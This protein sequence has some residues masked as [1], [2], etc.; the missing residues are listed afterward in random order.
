MLK[1]PVSTEDHVQGPG[2]AGVTLV[3]YGDY[4]CPYCGR[5]YPVVKRLQRHFG[6]GLRF[7][8]RNFPLTELHPHAE[9]AAETAEFAGA[10]NQFW[11]MH[12]LLFENQEHLGGPLYLE[13]VERLQLPATDLIEA[14]KERSF[15]L[16]VRED[17]N[18]AIRNGVEGTPTFFVNGQR[19]EGPSDFATLSAAIAAAA[20]ENR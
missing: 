7:V 10:R 8:F 11:A 6:A 5:A 12:D 13:L 4:Q 9:S 17:V 18:G 1:I 14:L 2:N 19:L 16:R 3:E 15:A 20:T